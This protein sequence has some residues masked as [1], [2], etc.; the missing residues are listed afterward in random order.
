MYHQCHAIKLD[1]RHS[2][3][4]IRRLIPWKSTEVTEAV[5]IEQTL[6]LFAPLHVTGMIPIRNDAEN[7]IIMERKN[8]HYIV[9][10]LH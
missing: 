2:G 7:M 1:Q 6:Y 3:L 9:I 4:Y 8:V 10:A 5:L